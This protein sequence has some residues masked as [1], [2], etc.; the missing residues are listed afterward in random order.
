M[1]SRQFSSQGALAG[2]MLSGRV[3]L[4]RKGV[5]PFLHLGYL[6]RFLQMVLTAELINMLVQITF[7]QTCHNCL[8][9]FLPGS[10]MLTAISRCSP[11]F[12]ML[13]ASIRLNS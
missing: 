7:K 9:C 5:L 3:Q 11:H 12:M 10:A 2:K 6:I 8:S 1:Y 13:F 4:P